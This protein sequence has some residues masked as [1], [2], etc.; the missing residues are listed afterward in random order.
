MT[1]MDVLR[2]HAAV[3]MAIQRQ[4]LMHT[5][6]R[7]QFSKTSVDHQ[8]TISLNAVR[9]FSNN[10]EF[11]FVLCRCRCLRSTRLVDDENDGGT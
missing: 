8:V 1:I 2:R 3:T 6:A 11:A 4:V 5:L 10:F 7:S 9:L